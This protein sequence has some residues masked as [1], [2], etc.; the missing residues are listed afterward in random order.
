MTPRSIRKSLNVSAYF[1][2]WLTPKLRNKGYGGI[3]SDGH[4]RPIQE[5]YDCTNGRSG[6]ILLAASLMPEANPVPT[7]L[8]LVLLEN[9]LLG[10]LHAM[11]NL[12]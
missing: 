12:R 5:L 11:Y 1:V 2:P 10:H 7:I 6:S 3:R 9:L 8:T 4:G